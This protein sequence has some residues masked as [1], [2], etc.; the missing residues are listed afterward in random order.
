[1][2]LTFYDVPMST[3]SIT[4]A[5]L[6]ELDIPCDRIQLSIQDG[7][8]KKPDSL[9]INPNGR[10]PHG[11]SDEVDCLKQCYSRPALGLVSKWNQPLETIEETLDAMAKLVNPTARTSYQN[12]KALFQQLKLTNDVQNCDN[13]ISEIGQSTRPDTLPQAPKIGDDRPPRE[14]KR[15]FPLWQSAIVLLVMSIGWLAV[16]P[17]APSPQNG[18]VRQ[19]KGEGRS[20]IESFH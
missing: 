6:V 1:M 18:E 12:A 4:E 8:T 20:T 15:S 9:K 3:S 5:V 14:K 7:D 17:H 16:K 2:S 13:A 19:A 11:W 10:V